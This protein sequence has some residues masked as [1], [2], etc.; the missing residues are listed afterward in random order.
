MSTKSTLLIIV[1]LFA[2]A[3][4]SGCGKAGDV[5]LTASDNGKTVDVK[6][7]SEIMITLEGNPST[8]Y[9]WE[10]KDLD[11]SLLQ[12]VGEPEFKSSNPAAV[13]SGGTITLTFKSLKAGST[14]LNLVYHRS[15]ETDVAPLSTYTVTIVAK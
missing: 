8:G 7:G 3:V 14:K 11:T 13:G 9:N 6:A 1:I 5:K 15:W 10:A 12:P 4:S 2:L